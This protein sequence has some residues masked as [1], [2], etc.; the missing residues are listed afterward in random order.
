MTDYKCAVKSCDQ[1]ATVLLTFKLRHGKSLYGALCL[2]H[3]TEKRDYYIEMGREAE[4]VEI[5]VKK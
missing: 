5:K 2:E 1:V 4:L 3:G